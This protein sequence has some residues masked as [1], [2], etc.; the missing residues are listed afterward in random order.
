MRPHAL[1]F[2]FLSC[3]TVLAAQEPT[4]RPRVGLVLSGGGARG[5]AHIGV[6]KVL[7]ELRVP[8]DCISGTSMGSIIGGLYAYGLSPEELERWVEGVDWPY[9]LQDYP[10]RV[11][12]AIRR[13]QE[14]YEFL[15]QLR[16]GVH[17]GKVA[18]PK[19]LLQGQNLGLVLDQLALEAHE[20]R[21]FDDLPIPFRCVAAD[22]VEGSRVVF[23][24]GDLPLALR[25]SMALPGIF[26]P[27][28]W[29]G[30]LLVD[31]GILDNLPV[32][33]ARSMGAVRLIAVDIGTPPSKLEELHD[34]FGITSQMVSILTKKYVTEA[35]ES[36][37]P[38]D[39]FIRP[40]L[41]DLS[42]AD[43]ERGEELIR[44]GTE[45]AR[46]HSAELSRFS[47]SPE[48]YERW[49]ARQR[50]TP[51]PLP[52]IDEIR[53]VTTPGIAPD[54]VAAILTTKEGDTLDLLR[55]R[56]DLEHVYGTD[57]FEKVRFRLL[58]GPE[59]RHVL[60]IKADEK[61]WGPGYLRFAFDTST[62]FD[63]EGGF[64][65]G[66]NY[67]HTA[68]GRTDAEWRT[69]VTLGTNTSIATEWFQPF[70]EKRMFFVAPAIGFERFPVRTEIAGVQ[71]DAIVQ[72]G[73]GRLDGGM[74]VGGW[75]ELRFGVDFQRGDLDFDDVHPPAEGDFDDNGLHASLEIDT[76]DASIFPKSGVRAR[77]TWKRRFE[78]LGS[79]EDFEVVDVAGYGVETIE[80]QSIAL[81]TSLQFETGGQT[82]PS[83]A[84]AVGGL[85]RV[86]GLGPVAMG[87]PEG[88][89]ASLIT[90]RRL[91]GV[92]LGGSVEAGGVWDGWDTINSHEV[93]FGGS[94]F[95]GLETPLGPIYLAYGWAENGEKSAYLIVGQIFF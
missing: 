29:E 52:V 10:R 68:I 4:P 72:R 16:V 49:R 79:D 45:W 37:S 64:T 38:E 93:I 74:H 8:V 28:E 15:V 43:F 77:A 27:V 55:L 6:L 71:T 89:V 56:R 95:S 33:A 34:L 61:S 62:D 76:L 19:G 54:L 9:I 78:S 31:G 90:Y 26:S 85:F 12:L 73:G 88:G 83:E 13:K 87:G 2:A 44:I 86:S 60:E 84:F 82:Q 39:V 66:L 92:Y 59:G 32:D 91:A 50:R 63:G 11:D 51:K 36:L 67:T 23:D 21:S 42:A 65:V 30:R 14:E 47:V 80:G 81:F 3:G 1:G 41:G 46:K 69:K 40:D 22:I 57:L 7:E 20:V 58:R 24:R 25:A 5:I 48:E 70:D 17:E 35:V 94:V 18:L 53:I 75:S